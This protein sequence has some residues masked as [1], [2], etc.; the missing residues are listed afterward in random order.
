MRYRYR[1]D[2]AGLEQRMPE[3]INLRRARK[4][5]DRAASE[6]KAAANRLVHGRTKSEK[7]ASRIEQLRQERSLDGARRDTD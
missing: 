4:A 6:T 3:V 2:V 7:Q 5:R 1:S